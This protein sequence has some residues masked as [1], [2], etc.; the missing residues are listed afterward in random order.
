MPPAETLRQDAETDVGD[1][2][3]VKPSDQ[4]DVGAQYA[5][6]LRDSPYTHEEEVALR[7]RF[8]RRILPILFFNVILASVDKTSTSTGAL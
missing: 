2:Q 3:M 8:D 5:G 4:L 6:Q 1:L 7:W